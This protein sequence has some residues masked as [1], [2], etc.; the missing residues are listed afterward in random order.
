LSLKL[1][2]DWIAELVALHKKSPYASGPIWILRLN[3]PGKFQNF[4]KKC[5]FSLTLISVT[6]IH[7][8]VDKKEY[9][10]FC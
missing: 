9:T 6:L 4:H 8:S 3:T 5:P 7:G 1:D 2:Q 10:I